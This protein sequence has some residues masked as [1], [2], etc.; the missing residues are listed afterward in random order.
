MFRLDSFRLVGNAQ[1]SCPRPR[2]LRS[3]LAAVHEDDRG[4]VS[5]ETVLII[6]AVAIPVLIVIIKFGWP[7]IKDYFDKGMQDLEGAGDKAISEG[8]N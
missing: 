2:S 3:L 7:K 6:A 4:S 8:S 1:P 5:L